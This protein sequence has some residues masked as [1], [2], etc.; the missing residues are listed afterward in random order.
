M[1]LVVFPEFWLTGPG[2]IG[3]VRRTVEDM[4]RLAISYPDPIFDQIGAFAQRHHVYVA[5][6]NFELHPKMPH[7]VFNSA[8]LIDDSGNLVHTYRKNQCADVWGLLPDTT[9]GSVLSEYLDRFG[10]AALFPWPIRLSDDSR[11]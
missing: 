4:E 3:A 5:F 11:T 2:G 10:E 9:P 6:Q 7:R 8:F 1:R